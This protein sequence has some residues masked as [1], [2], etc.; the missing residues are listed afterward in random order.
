LNII[1]NKVARTIT[2]ILKRNWRQTWNSSLQRA[3]MIIGSVLIT[4]ILFMLPS[5]FNQIEKRNGIVVNDYLLAA[6]PAYNVS[7]AIF[8]ILWGIGLYTLFRAIQKP[9]IY[10][11]YIWGLIFVCIL[12]VLTISLIPLNP[13]P[14][15]IALT[16]PLTGIFYGESNITKDLFFSGHTSTLFLMF[17]CL[18]KKTDKIIALAG[19][20]AVAF[21]LLVQHVHYT[22]DVVA[23]P[24]IVYPLYRFIKFLLN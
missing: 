5:F 18:E 6:L 7:I 13:P 17:L 24:I 19:T 20:I 22:V 15:L 12:R 3:Q 16:D 9:S 14:G 23:A 11:T 1:K 2:L 10:I 8:A 4:I 21:L